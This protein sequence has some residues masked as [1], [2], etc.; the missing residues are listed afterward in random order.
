MRAVVLVGGEGTRLRPLTWTTPKQMLPVAEVPMIERVL[1]HLREHGVDEVVLSLGY[2]P[3]AFITA[4]PDGRCAGVKLSYA[5]EPEPLDTAGA[6]RFAARHAGVAER[7]LA[8]DG[9]VL[10]DLDV[11]ALVAFH[12]QRGAEATI[13][14]TRV[15]DPSR[16]GVVPT[17]ADGRVVAFVEKPAPGTAP[18]HHINAG[19]YVLEPS[20]LDRIP[21]GR[22]VS[23]E[24]ETFPSL[25]TAGTLYARPDDSYW[26][27]TGTPAEY[28]QAQLDLIAGRRSGPPAPGAVERDVGVWT[29]GPAVVDG[30]VFAP[31]LIGDGCHVERD[32]RVERAVV[33]ARARVH[34]G[35]RV[36]CSVLL[37]GAIVRP[38]AVVEGSVVG[39]LAVVGDNARVG[40]GSV[41]GGRATVA[42]GA[43][44]EG[45]KVEAG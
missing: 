41:V 30:S 10:T 18:T 26:I 39:E 12:E 7:F 24:R 5:V 11:S 23:I 28:L 13:H 25:V 17:D 9:D 29:L 40:G 37:P 6:I 32:A 21:D 35:A 42:A 20:V 4:F 14:L 36:K 2:R 33:G 38:G 34:R 45:V 15:D 27:D 3:D 43:E 31:V 1:A 16:F 22:R 44:F 8:V 19:T